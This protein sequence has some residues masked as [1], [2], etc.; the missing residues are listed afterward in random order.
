MQID[1]L[2][3]PD[4][5]PAQQAFYEHV[6]DVLGAARLPFLVGGTF[7]FCFHTGIS[8]PTKD[9]DLFVREAD[10]E[11]VLA[12]FARAGHETEFTYPHWIG[13]VMQ[14]GLSVDFIF[15]SSNKLSPVTD[16]WLEHATPATLWGHEVLLS[17]PEEM[18]WQ[19]AFIQ[20]RERY[21][22]ADVA[23]LLHTC[24]DR[25]DWPRLVTHFGSYWRVLL[26]HLVLFGFIY[27]GEQ[28]RIPEWVMNLLVVRLLEE[29]RR[30]PRA[31]N[32][33]QGTLISRAQYLVDVLERG[34]G[35]ARL[36]PE[37]GMTP[38]EVILWT[39]GIEKDGPEEMRQGE[40]PTTGSAADAA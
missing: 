38:E 10:V 6:L 3:S 29:R 9:L 37:V 39:G 24:S 33:C 36:R 30:P 34:L 32:V 26:S 19:K 15:N 18:L 31:E 17:A 5:S 40:G 27:P 12:T 35:D 28:H 4:I 21:D 11:A 13:K 16:L 22:G 20:E 23:H 1:R 2:C 8:R 7:A 14:D 25:L